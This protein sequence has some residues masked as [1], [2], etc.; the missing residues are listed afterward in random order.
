ME[1]NAALPV[2][3][4]D[5]SLRAANLFPVIDGHLDGQGVS[6]QHACARYLRLGGNSFVRQ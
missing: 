6:W 4:N 3:R 2:K 5:D 1:I